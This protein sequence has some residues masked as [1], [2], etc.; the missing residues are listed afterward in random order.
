[1]RQIDML[2]YNDSGVLLTVTLYLAS[3]S[4]AQA[5]IDP[6][7]ASLVLQATIGAIAAGLLVLKI[8]WRKIKAIFFGVMKADSGQ[9][10]NQPG[11]DGTRR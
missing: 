11:A 5:Y 1:M 10:V 7:S 6:G 2:K 9:D 4:P 3:A 8:Y